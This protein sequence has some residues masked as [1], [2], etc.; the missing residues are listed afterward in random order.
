MDAA[1][2]FSGAAARKVVLLKSTC[3]FPTSGNARVE[4]VTTCLMTLPLVSVCDDKVRA[5]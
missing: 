1:Q 3:W 4:L 5:Y 2:A